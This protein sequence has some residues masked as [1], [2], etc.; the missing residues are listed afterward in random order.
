MGSIRFI[1]MLVFVSV[2]FFI[3]AYV[4][5]VFAIRAGL[6]DVNRD[7]IVNPADS[8]YIRTYYGLSPTGLAALANVNQDTFI[9][10]FDLVFVGGNIGYTLSPCELENVNNDGL[11][12][13]LDVDIVT[14][15]LGQS[16]STE[17]MIADLDGDGSVGSLDL[18]RVQACLPAPTST[19]TPTPTMTPTPQVSLTPD[20]KATTNPNIHPNWKYEVM[21]GPSYTGTPSYIEDKKMH[22]CL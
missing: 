17:N 5:P 19:L 15:Y 16:D 12:N 7:G 9:N 8:D 4:K 22:R 21:A 1:S 10:I 2:L 18:S 14:G 3:C 6:A 11:V 13:Q 20:P